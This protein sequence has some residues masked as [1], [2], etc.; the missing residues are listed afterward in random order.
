[1]VEKL[2]PTPR[3]IK[4]SDGKIKTEKEESIMNRE[5]EGQKVV[6]DALQTKD[7]KGSGRKMSPSGVSKRNL[8]KKMRTSATKLVQL[9]MLKRAKKSKRKKRP[10]QSRF[11]FVFFIT[12]MC[13]ICLHMTVR[14]KHR[15]GSTCWLEIENEV[16]NQC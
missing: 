9:E 13:L 15:M 14:K 11:L 4:N 8:W 3:G 12:K 10:F 5:K 16:S 1:M 2:P 7:Q 6:M